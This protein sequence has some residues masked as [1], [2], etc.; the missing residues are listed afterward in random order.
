MN[1]SSL[2]PGIQGTDFFFFF[3]FRGLEHAE[4]LT[5]K[6][7]LNKL[8]EPNKIQMHLASLRL[9]SVIY[10]MR[11]AVGFMINVYMKEWL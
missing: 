1:K 2:L 8:N 9:F 10:V 5:S 3:Q 6:C 11:K 7:Q 4:A